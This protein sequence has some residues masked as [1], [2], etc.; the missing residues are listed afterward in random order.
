MAEE[1]LGLLQ[2][3]RLG[4]TIPDLVPV[5]KELQAQGQLTGEPS[6]DAV[7]VANVLIAKQPQEYQAAAGR[8]WQAF[9]EALIAFLEKLL[10]LILQLIALFA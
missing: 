1:R 7:T 6:V 10:P 4:L 5:V 3:R 2:R 9:F 8:D